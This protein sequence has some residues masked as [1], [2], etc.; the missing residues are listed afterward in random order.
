M[1]VSVA[2][3]LA[4]HS[5][6]PIPVVSPSEQHLAWLALKSRPRS[7]MLPRGFDLVLRYYVYGMRSSNSVIFVEYLLVFDVWQS[8]PLVRAASRTG[9]PRSPQ[10]PLVL[11]GTK[12]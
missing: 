2:G 3:C 4:K 5:A 9:W 12:T 10:S 7:I 6:P 8:F 1:N 11:R